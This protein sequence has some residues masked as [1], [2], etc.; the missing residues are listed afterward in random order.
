MPSVHSTQ[1]VE[2]IK[3][4][5]DLSSVLGIWIDA[6]KTANQRDKFGTQ[7]FLQLCS[8]GQEWSCVF[9]LNCVYGCIPSD[10]ATESTP[11]IEEE[12]RNNGD[13]HI[14]GYSRL[15]DLVKADIGIM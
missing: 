4:R 3:Y 11:E 12:Q 15:H 13:R 14:N 7:C 5:T 10:L 6:L 1:L 8:L 2:G 9:V